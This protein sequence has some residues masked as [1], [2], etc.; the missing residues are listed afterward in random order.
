MIGIT[1][2]PRRVVVRGAKTRWAF[3]GH[4]A[5]RTFPGTGPLISVFELPG[6]FSS[7]KSHHASNMR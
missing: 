5:S 6:L 7:W 4:L 3:F 1:S 2:A